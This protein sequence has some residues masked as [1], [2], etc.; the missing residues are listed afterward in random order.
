MNIFNS[1]LWE[2]R[3]FGEEESNSASGC[4]A[5]QTNLP[6]G[7]DHLVLQNPPPLL[8]AGIILLKMVL[9]KPIRWASD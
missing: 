9:A 5:Q 2:H 3:K 4:Q 6:V 8:D 7:L 1:E